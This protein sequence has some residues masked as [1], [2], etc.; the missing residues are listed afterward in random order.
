MMTAAGIV[1]EWDLY[2]DR[3]PC[4]KGITYKGLTV[5]IRNKI[6][7]ADYLVQLSDD[8]GFCYS[9]IEALEEETPIITT[10]I[11][12]LE[13]LHIKD[14]E[15][16]HIVPF[17]MDFDINII[18]D[19]PRVNYTFDNIPSLEAWRKKLGKG[20]GQGI[21]VI[22][23]IRK[24]R[25]IQLDRYVEEGERLTVNKRRATEIIESGY[26]KEVKA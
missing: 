3:D 4:I 8:E 5:D 18:R 19:I 22:E 15:H 12:V 6:R 9:I 21:T 14:K 10:P 1:F 16:G 20:T 26:A 2:G 25:D 11:D 7:S 23:C 13:E 17:D 24:Y